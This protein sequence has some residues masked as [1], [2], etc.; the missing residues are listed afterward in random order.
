MYYLD[1]LKHPEESLKIKTKQPYKMGLSVYNNL[2]F[3]I[4]KNLIIKE[5]K[6]KG[7]SFSR[8]VFELSSFDINLL[9]DLAKKCKYRKPKNSYLC[10]GGAFYLHLQKIESKFNN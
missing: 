3:T 7:F 4:M 6:S 2:K 9:S 1:G 5:L 8:N 10:L